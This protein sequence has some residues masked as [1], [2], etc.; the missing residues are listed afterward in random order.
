MGGG[1]KAPATTTTIQKTELPAWLEG[2]TRENLA[3]ADTISKRPYE[4]YGG[5]MTAGFAPEQEAAFRYMQEGVGMT[6]PLYQRAAGVTNDVAGYQP[7]N[8]YNQNVGAGSIGFE[9]VNA[10]SFLTGNVDAYMNPYISNV[11][12]AALQRLE[13]ATKQAVNRI[14]DQARAA[15]AF[16]GSR[17]GIAE[18]T[19]LGEAARSAG[20]LSANL[21]SQGFNQAA[22]LMQ[23]DQQRAMQAALANQAAGITTGQTNLDAMM[24]AQLANQQANMQAQLANQ[25]AGLQGANLRMG[26][27]GQLGTLAQQAQ[28]AR[29]Q[30]ASVLEGIGGARQAQQQA[31]LDEAYARWNE[32]RNYPIEMLNMRLGA[33]SATP[34][35]ATSTTQSTMPRQSGNALMS[36]LGAVGTGVGIAANLASIFAF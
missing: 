11:E 2:I 6:T 7:S 16:G 14:G 4:A 23:A 13:G 12:N 19:A 35:S 33:T 15:G 25:S 32:Q 36:G 20:E 3:I 9:R 17:Q 34:Y 26:A 18:G 21:R 8:V 1:S 5:A 30:D 31:L 22:A 10:P 28:A 27:A 24:R 29:L